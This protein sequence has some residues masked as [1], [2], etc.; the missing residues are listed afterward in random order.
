M[1]LLLPDFR[2]RQRDYLLEITRAMTAQLDV[3]EVLRLILRASVAM[4]AGE[5][6][7]IALH[8]PRAGR[9]RVRAV[10]GVVAEHV[11]VFEPLLAPEIIDPE[12][13]AFDPAEF[14]RRLRSVAQALDLPLRQAVALP[15]YLGHEAIGMI[16]VVPHVFR[17]G[18]PQ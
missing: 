6:G 14:D 3:G 8:D 4:L 13:H 15:M 18:F 10:Y 5:A 16:Y 9:M 17:N 11:S 1:V 2:V 12:T 7:L